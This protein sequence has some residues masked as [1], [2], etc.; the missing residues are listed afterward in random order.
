MENREEFLQELLNINSKYDT[1]LIG[2]AYDKGRELHDGQLR[3]SGEPYFIHPINVALILASLGMDEAT[4]IG[5]LLH[6]AVED[7]DYTREELVADL[8]EIIF[9]L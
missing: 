2:K 8:E 1:E 7:T 3:K 6:D 5:G 9:I 4:I